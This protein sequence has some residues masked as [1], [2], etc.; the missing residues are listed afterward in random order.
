[1]LTFRDTVYPHFSVVSVRNHVHAERALRVVNSAST[2][3]VRL[4][5]AIAPEHIQLRGFY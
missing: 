3:L 1:M 2:I 4:Q 5:F